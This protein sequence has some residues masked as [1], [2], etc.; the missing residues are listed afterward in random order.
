MALVLWDE[1][2]RRKTGIDLGL[3]PSPRLTRATQGMPFQA[4]Q[5]QRVIVKLSYSWHSGNSKI[6]TPSGR[7]TVVNG[8]TSL[9]AHAQYLAQGSSHQFSSPALLQTRARYIAKPTANLFGKTDLETWQNDPCHVHMIVAP[10]ASYRMTDDALRTLTSHSMHWLEKRIQFPLE[11]K[12]AIHNDSNHRHVHLLIRCPDNG[13]NIRRAIYQA[14]FGD[15]KTQDLREAVRDIATTQVGPRIYRDAER[16]WKFQ[17]KSRQPTNLDRRLEQLEERFGRISRSR[18]SGVLADRYD[19]LES[20]RLI[21]RGQFAKEHLAKLKKMQ[22][23][24][25]R[26]KQAE[27]D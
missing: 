2:D 26:M 4:G 16:S 12:A 13:V 11:W 21:V 8:A 9:R 27:H 10:E 20:E 6:V 25:N 17:I 14:T 1:L 15:S 7:K 3:D 18:L 5:R 22:R 24:L 23:S 19:F